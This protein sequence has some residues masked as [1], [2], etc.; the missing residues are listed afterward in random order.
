MEE[1][2]RTTQRTQVGMKSAVKDSVG[3]KPKWVFSRYN[4]KEDFEDGKPFDI[5]TIHGNLILN[6]GIGV[7]QQLLAGTGSPDAFNNAN[8]HIGVGDS[9]DSVSA[10]QEGLQA[11]AN[12]EYV[13]ME[14]GY[15]SISGQTT[16]WRAV[17]DGDTGNFD[18]REFTV[19]NGDS[20][21][22][23]NLNRL[24]SDQGTK[25][26]GQIWTIDIEITWS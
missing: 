19:A 26:E 7:L 12:K 24:V 22:A 4:S 10:G 20:D 8:A 15:P 17:F 1:K 16:T 3:A 6:Q 23:D 18:W 2:I 21:A 14:S 25:A 5:S 9:D 13:G 11:G